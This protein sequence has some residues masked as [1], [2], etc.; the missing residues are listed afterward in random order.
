MKETKKVTKELLI[1][2][3][4]LIAGFVVAYF[5]HFWAFGIAAAERGGRI[6]LGGEVLVVPMVLLATYWV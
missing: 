4:V 3:M 2:A 5:A 6:A 1:K